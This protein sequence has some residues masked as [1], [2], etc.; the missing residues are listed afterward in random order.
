[1]GRPKALVDGWLSRSVEAL[2]GCDHVVV[3]LGAGAE[4]ARPL[5]HAHDVT[6]VVNPD[7]AE[8]MGTSLHAGLTHLGPGDATRCVLMLVDL[9]DVGADVVQRLLDVPG[10]E[11]ALA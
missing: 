8:G 11:T 5:L 6:I 9:P 1:M 10:Q 7:W 2:A 3:V 4:E